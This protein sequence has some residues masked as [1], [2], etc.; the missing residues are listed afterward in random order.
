[1][2]ING[3]P[4]QQACMTLVQDGM[5]IKKQDFTDNE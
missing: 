5:T 3:R 1:M 4:Y 2:E